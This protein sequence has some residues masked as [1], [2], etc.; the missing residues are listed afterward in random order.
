MTTN[1]TSNSF[2]ARIQM[3]LSFPARVQSLRSGLSGYQYYDIALELVEQGGVR[4][5]GSRSWC[6]WITSIPRPARVPLELSEH[7]RAT[8]G[9][10]A[11]PAFAAVGGPDLGRGWRRIRPACGSRNLIEMARAAGDRPRR[12]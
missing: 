4:G 10:L 1:P 3:R 9:Q 12:R 7:A 6:I 2:D 8:R 5:G 11:T